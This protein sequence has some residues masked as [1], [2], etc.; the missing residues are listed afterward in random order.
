[1]PWR[2]PVVPALSR[3]RQEDCL[4]SGVHDHPGQC[5]ETP[6][7]NRTSK[8]SGKSGWKERSVA[9]LFH[10]FGGDNLRP[11]WHSEDRLQRVDLVLNSLVWEMTDKKVLLV[12]HMAG[13]KTVLILL[14]I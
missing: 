8:N 1:M 3:L 7:Q 13:T 12:W 9:E 14:C 2:V 10:S 6:S 4:H 11:I 5:S